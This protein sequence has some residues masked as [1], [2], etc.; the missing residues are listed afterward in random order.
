MH[1]YLYA[2]CRIIGLSYGY[3]ERTRI[4]GDGHV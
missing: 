3:D 1:N 4:A 2:C